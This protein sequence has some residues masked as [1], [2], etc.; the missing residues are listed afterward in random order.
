MNGCFKKSESDFF[1]LVSMLNKQ[2]P[3]KKKIGNQLAATKWK[4]KEK[5]HRL[6]VARSYFVQKPDALGKLGNTSYLKITAAL[7]MLAYDMPADALEENVELSEIELESIKRFC[8]AVIAF[9]RLQ[10]LRSPTA[11]DLARILQINSV[12]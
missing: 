2:S 3:K 1:K 7:R 8:N 5:S 11:E 12:R 6:T 4:S 9:F 10:Y